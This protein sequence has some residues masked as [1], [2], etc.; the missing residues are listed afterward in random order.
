[1]KVL[2]NHQQY[3]TLLQKCN[4]THI[5]MYKNSKLRVENYNFLVPAICINPPKKKSKSNI[6]GKWKAATT[7]LLW[8][9]SWFR[10]NCRKKD[11]NLATYCDI[12]LE[13][14]CKAL[15]QRVDRILV[16]AWIWKRGIFSPIFPLSALQSIT[17]WSLRQWASHLFKEFSFK[18]LVIFTISNTRIIYIFEKHQENMSPHS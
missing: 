1:M 10:P 15:G 14:T 3:N 6:A 4:L 11:I 7:L 9:I 18:G 13:I 12:F 2:D 8:L 5:Y 16:V 17:S